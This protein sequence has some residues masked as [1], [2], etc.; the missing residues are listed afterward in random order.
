MPYLIYG[1]GAG[2]KSI[3]KITEKL[4]LNFEQNDEWEEIANEDEDDEEYE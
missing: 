1:K 2:Y 4:K 3:N